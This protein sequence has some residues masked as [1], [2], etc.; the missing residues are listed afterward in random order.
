LKAAQE[1]LASNRA[2][3]KAGI[4]SIVDVL[5]AEAAV[6]SRSNR[7]WSRRKRFETRKISCADCSICEED[8]RQDV[9]LIPLDQPVVTL[10][11]SACRS[12]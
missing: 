3:A 5:Q 2:K 10:E 7:Y 1:L 9:R 8:L 6:A 11:P 4:M 12:H